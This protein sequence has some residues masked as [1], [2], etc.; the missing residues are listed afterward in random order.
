MVIFSPNDERIVSASADNTLRIWDARTGRQIGEPLKEHTDSI[1]SVTFN[2]DGDCIVSA[3]RDGT[4]RTWDTN[5]GK[6]IK[7]P[8]KYP[9]SSVLSASF[10][11]DGKFIALASEDTITMWNIEKNKP[12]GKQIG[13]PF[14]NFRFVSSSS[15]GKHIVSYDSYE[16]I[17]IWNVETGEQMAEEHKKLVSQHHPTILLGF[18]TLNRGYNKTRSK[19]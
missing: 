18:G 13:S 6:Q 11:Q 10:S 9:L 15:D 4:I 14:N 1:F 16:D 2:H 17:I 5:T 8:I 19:K 12:T 7:D 3:S